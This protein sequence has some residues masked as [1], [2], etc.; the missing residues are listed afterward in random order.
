MV[1]ITVI[2]AAVIGAFVLEIGDRQETAPKTS[3]A[4]EEEG[5]YYHA[6]CCGGLEFQGND[7]VVVFTGI[8]GDVLD[9]TGVD[10]SVNGNTSTWGIDQDGWRGG[11]G[12]GSWCGDPGCEGDWDPAEPV[13]DFRPALGSNTA[14][15]FTAG[16]SWDLVLF[17]SRNHEYVERNRPYHFVYDDTD[18]TGTHRELLLSWWGPSTPDFPADNLNASDEVSVVWTADSGGRSQVLTKYTVQRSR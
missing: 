11:G 5:L 4:I 2:L 18:V 3:F 15:E 6:A 8:G 12:M 9:V 17:D 1:A 14:P 7:T 10:V 16:D 13:P